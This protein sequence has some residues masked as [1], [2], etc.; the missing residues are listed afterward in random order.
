MNTQY[1]GAVLIAPGRRLPSQNSIMTVSPR[2]CLGVYLGTIS[3][4]AEMNLIAQKR[5]SSAL[6]QMEV[7]TWQE[8]FSENQSLLVNTSASAY[9][10][11]RPRG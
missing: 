4:P 7:Y 10:E 8:I 11:E 1:C 5:E 9:Y 2:H 3:S 6:Y